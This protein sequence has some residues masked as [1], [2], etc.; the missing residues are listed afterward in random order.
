MTMSDLK[1]ASVFADSKQHFLIL[2]ALR[3]V[4]ALMVV[5]FH[6]FEIYSDGD[7]VKQFINH[8]YLAVDFF[9]MLS[10]YVMAHAYDDR[11][12][13][14]SLKA[15]FKRRLIRLHPMIIAGMVIG[16]LCFFFQ[17]S[18]M[19]PNI[20]NTSLGQMLLIFVIGCTLVPVP[21]SMDIRGWTEMH[22]L[23]GPAWS[24]FFEYIAN[25]LHALI[26]RH[27]SK[28]VLAVLL[29]I[30]AVALIHL[31][32]TSPKGDI[33]GGW[34][35]DAT[36]LHIGFTRLLFPYLAGMLLRRAVKVGTGKN[37]FVGTAL[38]L[39]AAL[40]MPRI[41]GYEHLWA[42]GLY[43]SLTVILLFPIIIYFG[44][45]GKVVGNASEKIC[46]FL[47]DISYPIYIIHYPIVYIFY[48]W[49]TNN[50]VPIEEGIWVGMSLFPLILLLSY[51]ALKGY[52]ERVRK[53]LAK[54][55]LTSDLKSKTAKN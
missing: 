30:A 54:K 18:P 34:S 4:A 10:G 13:T 22:P 20:A 14:M 31:G 40:G 37:T 7:H 32:V 42:N 35:I 52:D 29:G 21:P 33:I 6:V 49:V 43:D 11:W 45:T 38:L 25:I 53:W 12:D 3:G 27:L 2:D 46:T 39:I 28:L 26:L 36:Q 50:Q 15:F 9:F 47:G 51:A 16:A 23:N 48:A 19:F 44:A 1:T 5:L 41:G 24:L 55:F 8:G 17:E